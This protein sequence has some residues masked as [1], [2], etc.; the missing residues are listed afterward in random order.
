MTILDS[1]LS[2]IYR[3]VSTGKGLE[4]HLLSKENHG[5]D[6]C[7]ICILTRAQMMT[8]REHCARY[9]VEVDELKKSP[10]LMFFFD[11]NK[12]LCDHVK[13]CTGLKLPSQDPVQTVAE[14]SLLYDTLNVMVSI[15]IDAQ[16][17]DSR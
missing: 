16:T 3:R 12:E 15:I 6:P 14:L 1:L 7:L 17:S 5:P 13:M 4:Y 9:N 10:G 2:F 8:M 11:E